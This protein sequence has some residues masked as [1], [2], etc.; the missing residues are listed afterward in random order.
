MR[1]GCLAG[2]RWVI[3][4]RKDQ[5]CRSSWQRSGCR[6]HSAG[7]VFSCGIDDDFKR[8]ACFTVTP[9]CAQ[10]AAPPSSTITCR[11][12]RRWPAPMTKEIPLTMQPNILIL[13][14]DQLTARALPAYGNRV[15]KTP[16]IDSL[17]SAAS[18]L[19][20]LLQQPAVRALALLVPGRSPGLG[21]WCL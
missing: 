19:S 5:S 21:D 16:H 6:Q 8:Q 7:W 9:A 12:V 2:Q 17:A 3:E 1:S 15:A 10:V 20:P 14:A 13:M 4:R 18:Y 11:A